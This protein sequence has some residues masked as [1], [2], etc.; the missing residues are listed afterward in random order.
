MENEVLNLTDHMSDFSTFVREVEPRLN[1]A[2]VA[3]Y[4]VEVGRDAARDAL[5]YA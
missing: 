3:S 1:R 5:A 4:G 2:L